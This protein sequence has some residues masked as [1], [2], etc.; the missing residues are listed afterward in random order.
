[1]S[2]KWAGFS[3]RDFIEELLTA[4]TVTRRESKKRMY[5]GAKEILASSKRMA[6]LED[7]D[8]EEAHT[9]AT[10]RLN[11]DQMGVEIAVESP[12]AAVQHERLEPAGD[13]KRGVRSNEKNERAL[14]GEEVGG[15]FLERAIELHEDRIANEVAET[16]PGR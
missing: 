1:M 10:T 15:K 9:I 7:G 11:K 12:Y 2:L 4:N 14:P 8:L 5:A 16:L 13:W 6:P 3:A